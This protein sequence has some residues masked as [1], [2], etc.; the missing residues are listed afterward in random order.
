M[1]QGSVRAG[2]AGRVT[3]VLQPEQAQDGGNAAVL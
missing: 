2:V 3:S 1:H